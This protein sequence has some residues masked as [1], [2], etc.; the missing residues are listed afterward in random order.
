[1]EMMRIFEIPSGSFGTFGSLVGSVAGLLASSGL[2][3]VVNF[4]LIVAFAY[5]GSRIGRWAADASLLFAVAVAAAG[6]AMFAA[7]AP[8][9][10]FAV[11]AGTFYLGFLYPVWEEAYF[12][13]SG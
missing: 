3:L 6:A 7:G 1:M 12:R 11:N 9:G 10:F 2:E 8:A 5:A 13:V 4:V